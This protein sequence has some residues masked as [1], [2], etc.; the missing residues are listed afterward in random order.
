[1]PKQVA[2]TFLVLQA[3]RREVAAERPSKVLGVLLVDRPGL[4]MYDHSRLHRSDSQCN[5][6]ASQWPV[7]NAI[8]VSHTVPPTCGSLVTCLCFL[9][10]EDDHIIKGVKSQEACNRNKK[11]GTWKYNWTEIAKDLPGRNHKMCQQR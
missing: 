9:M 10:Q 7:A 1:M 2:Y 5:S 6:P 3:K 11:K 8:P 4:N